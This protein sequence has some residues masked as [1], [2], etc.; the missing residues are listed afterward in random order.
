MHMPETKL[1]SALKFARKELAR[2]RRERQQLDLEIA[3][4]AQV[5]AVLKPVADPESDDHED[6]GLTDGIRAVLRGAEWALTPTE[7]RDRLLVGG[8]SEDDY[9]QFLPAVH[10]VLKRLVNSGEAMYL[11][12]DK[13]FWWALNGP[14]PAPRRRLI[15]GVHPFSKASP[16]ITPLRG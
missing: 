1:I 12:A 9:R 4:M 8:F 2:L 13:T 16:P 14:P 7:V 5:V 11:V 15:R 10:V 3:K 6:I